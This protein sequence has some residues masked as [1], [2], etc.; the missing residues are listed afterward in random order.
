MKTTH[1]KAAWGAK[2]SSW[3]LQGRLK[4]PPTRIHHGWGIKNVPSI[5]HPAKTYTCD[6]TE[7]DHYLSS[8]SSPN[9]HL[10]QKSRRCKNSKKGRSKRRSEEVSSALDSQQ[11]N[12]DD[13]PDVRLSR[14]FFPGQLGWGVSQTSTRSGTESRRTGWNAQSTTSTPT[15]GGCVG[16]TPSPSF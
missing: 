3:P 13:S 2:Y 14:H 7:G 12:N 4:P 11:D 5:I 16:N 6:L 8:G 10:L 15:T 1:L 9:C